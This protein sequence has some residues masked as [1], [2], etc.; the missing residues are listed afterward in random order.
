MSWIN[1]LRISV[2]LSA[3]FAAI[4]LVMGISRTTIALKTRKF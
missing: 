4:S 3:V 2:K 1:D